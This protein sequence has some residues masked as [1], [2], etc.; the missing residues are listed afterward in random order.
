MKLLCTAL[1]LALL[2][3]G[4]GQSHQA[5]KGS[6]AKVIYAASQERANPQWRERTCRYR[7]LE[8]GM[9][10]TQHEVVLT[11]ECAVSHWS[12]PGGRS[13]A[14]CIASHESGLNETNVN[15]SSGAAGV[16]QWM[17]SQWPNV[18][19]RFQE[20]WRRWLLRDGILNAR[21]NVI[22]AIRTAHD[23]SWSPWTTAGSCG[24]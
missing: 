8:G 22:A 11:I 10:W 18:Q 2:L 19:T 17:P 13:A 1:S 20:L 9:G 3:G 15:P 5:S 16:Y 6:P 24:V 14:L 4:G 23:G 7:H 12:V 21:A